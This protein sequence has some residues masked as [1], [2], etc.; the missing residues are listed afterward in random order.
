MERIG[1]DSSQTA[2]TEVE[3]HERDD[4]QEGVE[5]ADHQL[6]GQLDLML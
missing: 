4:Q 5:E 6:H 1:E 3:R 2:Q